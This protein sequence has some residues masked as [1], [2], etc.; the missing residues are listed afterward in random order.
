MQNNTT[1]HW[2]EECEQAF[3]NLKTK[4]MKASIL[5]YPRFDKEASPLIL[6]TDASL[7]GLGAILEHDS[8]VITYGSLTLSMSNVNY[9]VIQCKSLAVVWGTKQFR[10]Y[11]RGCPLWLLTDHES[12]KWLAEQTMEGILCW[13]AI[14][15][16]IYLHHQV[17]KRD[18][19]W[20]C[21]CIVQKSRPQETPCS[22]YNSTDKHAHGRD[23]VCAATG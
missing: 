2:T 23:K 19:K 17:Q 15:A 3:R 11:L 8:Q 13:W 1:Y 21:R 10:H 14:A 5:A 22:S 12:L 20:K 4:L 6:Q 18:I 16:G 7:T 9:S